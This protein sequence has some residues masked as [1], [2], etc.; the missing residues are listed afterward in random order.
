MPKAPI[1]YPDRLMIRLPKG[2]TRRLTRLAKQRET[3]RAEF[4]R[5]LIRAALEK[6]AAN[7]SK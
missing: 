4:V 6:K 3:S 1:A 2:W 5:Q 7:E